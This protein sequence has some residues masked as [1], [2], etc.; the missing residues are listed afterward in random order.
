VVILYWLHWLG[1]IF[2]KQG[3]LAQCGLLGWLLA[4]VVSSAESGSSFR[5]RSRF[6]A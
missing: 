2:G 3:Q 6:L 5:L 1:F 4:V